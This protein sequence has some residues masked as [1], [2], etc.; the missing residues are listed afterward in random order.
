MVVLY[1]V[2]GKDVIQPAPTSNQNT[3]ITNLHQ[4]IGD[5]VSGMAVMLRYRALLM[6]SGNSRMIINRNIPKGGV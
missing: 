1:R 3:T 4:N 6:A 5:N 2:D